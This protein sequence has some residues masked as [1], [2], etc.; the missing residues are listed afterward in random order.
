MMVSPSP[1]TS[2]YMNREKSLK[3]TPCCVWAQEMYFNFFFPFR[4]HKCSPSHTRWTS[5]A[6]SAVHFCCRAALSLLCW[7]QK[8]APG[9]DQVHVVENPGKEVVRRDC[10]ELVF[11][12]LYRVRDFGKRRVTTCV[13]Q[14]LHSSFLGIIPPPFTQPSFPDI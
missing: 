4:E 3:I 6:G 2:S 5:A 1:L 7:H 10:G 8:Q 11:M 9:L 13:V 12:F 14:V